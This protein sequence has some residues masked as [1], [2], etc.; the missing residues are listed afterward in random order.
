MLGFLYSWQFWLVAAVVVIV[1]LWILS[2]FIRPK[3]E[4]TQ[5]Y[6]VCPE[7]DYDIDFQSVQPDSVYQPRYY[8]PPVPAP[9]MQRRYNIGSS[10]D[11]VPP[12]PPPLPESEQVLEPF[13]PTLPRHIA[14]PPAVKTE[15]ISIGEQACK[16][17]V[18]RIYGVDFVKVRPEWLINPKTG[19]RLELDLYND[20]LKLAVEFHGE[21]HYNYI[22]HW[23]RT[24]AG[25]VAQVE[26]DNIKLKICDARGVYVITVP[27]YCPLDKIEDYIRFYDPQAYALRQAREAELLEDLYQEIE[28]EQV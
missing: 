6:T 22:P 10:Y 15:K 2:K 16:D 19:R 23:H 28:A 17:A 27:Y 26:R 4:P 5:I 12:V 20:D 13:I 21:Q 8:Q 11:A 25:Y 18:K 1:L 3:Q 7:Y 14:E 24:Y 9:N